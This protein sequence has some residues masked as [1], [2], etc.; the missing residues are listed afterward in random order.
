MS[1]RCVNRSRFGG[2]TAAAA[3]ADLVVFVGGASA[4][5]E[6]MEGEAADKGGI[7]W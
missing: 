4:L 7:E 2:A 5:T 6:W 1:C 3:A